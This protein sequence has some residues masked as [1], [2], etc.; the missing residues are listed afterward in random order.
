[1]MSRLL[2]DV[3]RMV[4]AVLPELPYLGT[5]RYRVV[6]ANP[7]DDRW[8]LQA[9]QSDRGLPDMIPI[10]VRPGM[11]GLKAGLRPG[12]IVLVTFIEGDRGLPVIT[13]HDEP[14][15]GGWTPLT[16]TLDASDTVAVGPSAGLVELGSGT[17]PL[18]AP[19]ETGRIVRFGDTIV[20]TPALPS[21]PPVPATTNT[22]Y[23]IGANQLGLP[24]TVAKVKA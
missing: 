2:H 11:A 12:S 4:R 15:T 5:Y 19:L 24:V 21:V 8:H 17:E 16:L 9:V 6:Q 3:E 10:P 23:V 18:L 22:P 20:L 7:G 1:M 13:H 14:G